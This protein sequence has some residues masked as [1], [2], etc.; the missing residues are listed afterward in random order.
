MG[1][2]SVQLIRK[3]HKCNICKTIIGYEK[4]AANAHGQQNAKYLLVSEAPG[5]ESLIREQYWTGQ[6]GQ[7]L[8]S[9]TAEANT[10]L[11]KL[12]YL[13][14]IVK[15]WPNENGENRTPIESEIQNCSHFLTKE[16]EELKPVLILSFGKPASEFL[17]NRKVQLK[18]EHG[19]LHQY[20]EAT[21]ILVL[22]HPTGIDR[23]MDRTTYKNQL[24]SL[25]S[26]LKEGKHEKIAE[27]FE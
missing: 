6:G 27:I 8:R 5:K 7:I 25:F 10:T 16:I 12:F 22:L 23:Q 21:R 20:N 18:L 11:E 13:T 24:I 15:C 9:C 1:E 17:L 19:T 14:D 3:I 26:I 4:F 2:I